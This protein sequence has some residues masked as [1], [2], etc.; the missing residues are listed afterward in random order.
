VLHLLAI[1]RELGVALDLDDFDEISART[2]L[3]AD[4]KPGG[5]YVA[6]TCT[7][8]A[9]RAWSPAAARGGLLHAGA[10]TVTGR[11]IGE[12]PRRRSRPRARRS[13]PLERP[14]KPTG[15][16]VILR[17]N[18]APDGCVVKV[19]GPRPRHAH[20]ARRACSTSEEAAFEAVQAAPS[21][22]ETSS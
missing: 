17:G 9:A 14:L 8:P 22:R 15:G 21:G 6:P 12:E 2:P 7:A 11:T 4:L 13:S 10:L 1:A 19:A 16:L 3:L 20:T 18:L 5:R